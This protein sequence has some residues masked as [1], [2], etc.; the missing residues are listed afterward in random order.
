MLMIRDT[1]PTNP[2]PGAKKAGDAAAEVAKQVGMAGDDY[3]VKR[4]VTP[5]QMKAAFERVEQAEKRAR[6]LGVGTLGAFPAYEKALEEVKA[7]KQD[8]AA[9]KK[10]A[11]DLYEA[12]QL[13][14]AAKPG[15][16]ARFF[17][18]VWEVAKATFTPLPLAILNWL[19]KD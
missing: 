6:A 8:L 10:A 14:Q 3:Q 7:A 12:E 18:G 11:P 5:E 15:V 9:L 19:K 13:R 2:I 4:Q 17:A 1:Q 16:F